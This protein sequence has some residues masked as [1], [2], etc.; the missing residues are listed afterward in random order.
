MPQK[1]IAECIGAEGPT[2]VR[3]LDGLERMGLIERRGEPA[4]RRV[5]RVRLTDQASTVLAQIT[6]ITEGFRREMWGGVSDEDIAAH[7][8]VMAT[9]LRNLGAPWRAR[10]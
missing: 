1:E 3:V 10:G 6:R 5:K 8:R 2:V 7:E 4:D 9:L